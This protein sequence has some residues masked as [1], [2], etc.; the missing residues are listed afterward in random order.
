MG[1]YIMNYKE[2]SNAHFKIYADSYD[3]AN[4][5]LEDFLNDSYKYDELREHMNC[6]LGD[7]K[8]CVTY[9]K[10]EEDFNRAKTTPTIDFVIGEDVKVDEPVYD[11]YFIFDENKCHKLRKVWEDITMDRVM[12]LCQEVNKKYILNPRANV[13]M[14]EYASAMRRKATVLAYKLIKRK[15]QDK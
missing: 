12:Q 6:C 2:E 3:E 15:E 5:K 9:Y 14:E 1:I 11:L 4:E 10:T 8:G 13:S 7:S